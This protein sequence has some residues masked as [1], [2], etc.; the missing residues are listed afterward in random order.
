MRLSCEY[1]TEEIPLSYQ[2]LFV[3]LIKEALKE[4]D[5][6]FQ[7]KLYNYDKNRRN[8]QSKDFTFGVYLKEFEKKE[9]IF[10]IDDRVILNFSTPNYKLAVKFYN[11]LLKLGE[12]EYKNFLL[13]KLRINL[14]K[15]KEIKDKKIRFKTLSPVCIKNENNH[16]L[17]LDDKNYEKELN[18]IANIVLENYRG[19]GLKEEL[20]FKPL[21]MD[22]VVVKQKIKEFTE[23][24]GREYYYV[25]SYQGSFELKG[26]RE[27]LQDIYMLGLGFKRNQGFG[28]L[29]VI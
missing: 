27:D 26:A 29:E 5:E 3:S 1:E 13:E 7:D 14:E 11:G 24:T 12:F 10:K 20:K 6:E 4:S 18:Y 28:M 22:K 21:D 19:Y 9:D 25:N 16:F 15:E 23:N 17:D 8:K 2:M